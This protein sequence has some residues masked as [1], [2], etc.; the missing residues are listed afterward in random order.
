MFIKRIP[1]G[2]LCIH[3]NLNAHCTKCC[4]S[5]MFKELCD[6]VIFSSCL[7]FPSGCVSKRSFF[8]SNIIK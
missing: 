7:S 6:C 1:G 5:R 3:N 4:A 2:I 8:L